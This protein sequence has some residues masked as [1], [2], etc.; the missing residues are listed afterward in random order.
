MKCPLLEPAHR[1]STSARENR[2]S[3]EHILRIDIVSFDTS[4][5]E[6]TFVPQ[7]HGVAVGKTEFEISTNSPVA[8]SSSQSVALAGW[9]LSAS[10][11]TVTNTCRLSGDQAIWLIFTGK[12]MSRGTCHLTDFWVPP[13]S[14]D[15]AVPDLRN[16]DSR[17]P[18]S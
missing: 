11:V 3:V 15:L 12:T 2:R 14:T 1:P 8:T 7:H 13:L 5:R 18:L 16:H 17:F 10:S 6:V 9:Q 4:F